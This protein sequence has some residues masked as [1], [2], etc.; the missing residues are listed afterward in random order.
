MLVLRLQST[1]PAIFSWA[2]DRIRHRT[3]DV[4]LLVEELPRITDDPD[5]HDKLWGWRSSKALDT[6]TEMKGVEFWRNYLQGSR[7]KTSR[8]WFCENVL[9]SAERTAPPQCGGLSMDAWLKQLDELTAEVAQCYVRELRAGQ[10]PRTSSKALNSQGLHAKAAKPAASAPP[11]AATEAS[12]QLILLARH[13]PW[14]IDEYRELLL[15]EL[16]SGNLYYGFGIPSDPADP[17]YVQGGKKQ[18]LMSGGAKHLKGK[19]RE[20]VASVLDYWHACPYKREQR[21][22]LRPSGCR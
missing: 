4:D 12:Y 7:G 8:A 11:R 5:P 3:G 6:I 13:F 14:V 16:T 22:S 1:N 15:E 9:A 19:S 20:E 10:P 17:C 21:R 2:L 18:L